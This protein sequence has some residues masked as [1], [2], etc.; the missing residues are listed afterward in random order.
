M[1][2]KDHYHTLYHCPDS[3]LHNIYTCSAGLPFAVPVQPCY[4]C[5]VQ[6]Q[7]CQ[8]T[9]S[10]LQLTKQAQERQIAVSLAC[11]LSH[12]Q[13]L[14]RQ[15]RIINQIGAVLPACTAPCVHKQRLCTQSSRD[16]ALTCNNQSAQIMTAAVMPYSCLFLGVHL[17]CS[18]C[19]GSLTA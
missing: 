6:I 14:L 17:C 5:H 16:T 9:I 15:L 2:P 11:L 12:H 13:R 4:V 3:V 10:A 18:C 7:S 8:E 1:T 19:K